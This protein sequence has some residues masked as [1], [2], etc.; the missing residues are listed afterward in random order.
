[1][2]IVC[3]ADCGIDRHTGHGID[4]AG[5]IG[6]NVAIHTRRRCAADATVTV[7]A[8]LGDD[9]GA[10]LVRDAAARADVE[11]CFE[12]VPG[13]TP[14]QYIRQSDDGER[15]F[16][17]FDE[18][19]LAGFRVSERQRAAIAASDV[20]A[21]AAFAQGL[22]FFES[23]LGCKPQ[24]LRLVDF[25]NANDVGDPVAFAT[26]WAPELDVGL[27][28]L[29]SED[30]ALIEALEGVARHS[31]RLFIVTLGADG[32]LALS[33]GPR[34]ACAARPVEQ[35]LD[36]TGAGDAFTAGFLCEFA[37]SRN[38]TRSLELGTELAASTLHHISSF[39]LE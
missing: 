1:M 7:V 35:V 39:E 27:F 16:D 21:T 37:H 29:R 28:G 36:T 33:R 11:P 12:V 19:V 23:V 6:L 5:G 14:V 22:T 10:D 17:R 3:A 38:V 20:L 2:K 30:V 31:H 25:T 13:A 9:A 8:P 18:G 26:R 34:I 32:A 15:A 4:R 24:G